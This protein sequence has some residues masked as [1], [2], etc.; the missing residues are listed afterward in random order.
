M[1]VLELAGQDD[2][3]AAYEAGSAASDVGLLA[4]GLATARAV[5]D[6]V[7]NLAFTHRASE[8]LGRADPTVEDART[9][10][11]AATID[12][13]GTVAVRA[14][15]VRA[16]TGIDTQA[17]ERELGTV[18]VDRGFEV[19]LDRPDNELR[20]LFAAGDVGRTCALGWLAV[21]SKRD[22][23]T[24]QPG[25]RPF[26][27]PGSMDPMLACA[28]ANVAGA[29][30]RATVL[31]PMCGTGGILLEAGLVGA[32]V[33]GLDRQEKMVRGSRTNLDAF[34]SDG[35]HVVQGDASAIPIATG[36]VD[37]VV[38][39]TPY[40]RQSKIAG[41]LDD[42]VC[43]TLREARRVA[44]SCVIVGDRPWT[45]QAREAGWTIDATFERRVHRSLTRYI[46]VLRE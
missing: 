7:G 40:G 46:L 1:Y 26:F 43:A 37:A 14:V 4:P 33:V 11:S 13:E 12:R 28:L 38:F 41:E 18:L 35:W 42:L 17:V 5:S 16:T 23:G 20:A 44:P 6:R 22:Y 30:P 45:E 32:R 10:L 36:A 8:L 25:D 21:E 24:R 15:D 2:E 39:D 9:L 19:D 31:D 27:Q 3:F 34:L 29:R